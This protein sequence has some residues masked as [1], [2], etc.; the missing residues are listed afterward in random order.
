MNTLLQVL[1]LALGV[2]NASLTPSQFRSSGATLSQSAAGAHPADRKLVFSPYVLQQDLSASEVGQ[3]SAAAQPAPPGA[4]TGPFQDAPLPA[5]GMG[6]MMPQSLGLTNTPYN[7]M[8]GNAMMHPL[9]PMNQMGG[10][11][12]LA[13]QPL[14]NGAQG[15][16]LDDL[17]GDGSRQLVSYG[18]LPRAQVRVGSYCSNVRKQAVEVANAIMKSQNRIIFKELMNY[19]LKSKYLIGMTEVRLTRVL[20]KKIYGLMSEYSSISQSNVQF[21]PVKQ[22]VAASSDKKDNDSD[23]RR[24]L[25]TKHSRK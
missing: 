8:Y 14:G 23:S 17:S 10:A 15:D 12:G 20:R 3:E 19:L 11:P 25:A 2:A 16:A 9:N 5:F 13:Q 1:L 18:Q 21:I 7:Y 6:G 22:E 24:K 4:A